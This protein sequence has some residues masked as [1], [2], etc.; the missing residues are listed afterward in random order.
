MEEAVY[1]SKIKKLLSLVKFDGWRKAKIG[2]ER[3][4]Y[5]TLFQYMFL[6]LYYHNRGECVKMDIFKDSFYD[7]CLQERINIREERDYLWYDEEFNSV[8]E[9][10]LLT[11]T[12]A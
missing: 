6:E 10:A 12:P 8:D 3:D 2:T 9:D 7:G 4:V 11:L 5:V 1:H